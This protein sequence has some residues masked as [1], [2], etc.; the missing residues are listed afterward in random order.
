MHVPSMCDSPAVSVII[1]TYNRRPLLERALRSLA[2]QTFLDFETIVCDDGS[3][4]DTSRL[5]EQ[6]TRQAPFSLRYA[7][8]ARGGPARARNRGIALAFGEFVALLDSDDTYHPDKLS[9]Q[10][11][12]MRQSPHLVFCY[13]DYRLMPYNRVVRPGEFDRARYLAG[14]YLCCASVI[15]RRTV[16]AQIGG[17]DE[18][19]PVAED[20]DLLLRLSC[21]GAVRGINEALYDYYSHDGQISRGLPLMHRYTELVHK[22]HGGRSHNPISYIARATPTLA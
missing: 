20:W 21:L 4:D 1:P 10:V 11:E 2:R 13:T 5:I 17:Y 12:M 16:I 3:S 18:S 7:Y 6:W 8:Q 22:K 19:L 15:M 14:N 9:L